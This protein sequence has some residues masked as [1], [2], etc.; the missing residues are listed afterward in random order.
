MSRST[1]YIGLNS[2]AL[3]FVENA[4]KVEEYDMTEGIASEPVK[5]KIYHISP[6]EGPNKEYRLVEVVQVTPWSSGPMILTCLKEVLVK[7][8]GEIEETG[9]KDHFFQWMIDPS[10]KEDNIEVDCKTGRYYA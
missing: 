6:P 5:G 3:R 10:L 1:Q 9:E 4:V 8:S 2:Y 7:E